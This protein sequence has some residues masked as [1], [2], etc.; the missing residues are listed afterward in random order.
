MPVARTLESWQETITGTAGKTR[1]LRG[2]WPVCQLQLLAHSKVSFPL[3]AS[4]L[5]SAVRSLQKNTAIA[6]PTSF[7]RQ[8]V[9]KV[10]Q[11]ARSKL[12][13]FAMLDKF[14][15]AAQSIHEGSAHTTDTV[16]SFYSPIPPLCESAADLR[17]TSLGAS[18]CC[19]GTAPSLGWGKP[20]G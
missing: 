1:L 14:R 3:P 16:G 10:R 18:I 4:L 7:L 6:I 5:C 13:F 12:L 20:K 15:Q 8:K 11:P 9:E 19:P 17:G 2:L